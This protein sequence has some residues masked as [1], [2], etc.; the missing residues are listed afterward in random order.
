MKENKLT[1]QI[2]KP[3][4]EAFAFPLN[5]ANTPLWVDSFVKEETNEWPVKVGTI[6]RSQNRDGKW[7]EYVMAGFVPR[8]VSLT[9]LDFSHPADRVNFTV[10]DLKIYYLHSVGTYG[11]SSW[12]GGY[13]GHTAIG[14]WGIKENWN[15]TDFKR[16]DVTYDHP[17][18]H[19]LDGF[20][21]FRIL[22]PTCTNS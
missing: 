12:Y 21:E 17:G 19:Q 14:I 18:G 16:L 2:K 4:Q 13:I 8:G 22:V 15:M 7:S 1:I 11:T 6:Y 20:R 9:K 3:I 10:A 5:P